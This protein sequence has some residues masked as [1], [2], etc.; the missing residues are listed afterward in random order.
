VP[1]DLLVSSLILAPGY[2][3]HICIG[4]SECTV[5]GYFSAKTSA[6]AYGSSYYLSVTTK[7]LHPSISYGKHNTNYGFIPSAP[8]ITDLKSRFRYLSL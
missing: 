5:L 8:S 1:D 7:I 6:N 2:P 3:S 4:S